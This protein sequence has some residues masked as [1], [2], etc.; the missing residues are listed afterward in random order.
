MSN[1]QLFGLRSII[2]QSDHGHLILLIVCGFCLIPAFAVLLVSHVNAHEQ[3]YP[4]RGC[5]RLGRRGKSNLA[6]EFTV[7]CV[8]EQSEDSPWKVKSLWVYPFKSC[9]GVELDAGAVISTGMEYDRVFSLAQL[10]GPSSASGSKSDADKSA[11]KWEFITQRQFPLMAL[12]RTEIWVP[13]LASPTHSSSLPEVKSQGVIVV[14]FPYRQGGLKGFVT[15]AAATLTGQALEKTFQIPFNPT[16]K[17]I[18]QN[19]YFLEEMKIWKDSPQAINMTTILPPELKAAL[20][21]RNPLGLFRIS[22]DHLRKVFRCAPS[23]EELGYQAVTGFA[24]AYPLHIMNLASSLDVAQRVNDSIPL[25]SVLRFRPNIIITGP[26]A[27]EEDSWK[28]IRIGE[29]EYYV[30]CRTTR[31][32]LPNTDQATGEKH[33]QEP[34]KTLSTY[35]RIDEGAAKNHCLGMQM[36]PA[37]EQGV[38]SVGDEIEVLETGEHFYLKQ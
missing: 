23:K 27:Y 17:Q 18:K 36:V 10:K 35:R 6:D 20:G 9:K 33:A 21:V 4:P 12:V 31:C 2:S 25:L 26:E 15:R 14:R 16:E 3:S 32:M 38:I 37:V 13:D 28:R 8:H 11:Y 1:Y 24:D 29:F 30:S 5:K 19:S 22:N 7:D 34:Y